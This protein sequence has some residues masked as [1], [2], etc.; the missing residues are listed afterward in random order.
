MIVCWFSS[1]LKCPIVRVSH[2]YLVVSV[3][4]SSVDIVF[5]PGGT[6]RC[7]CGS[8]KNCAL[9]HLSW[10]E[11]PPFRALEHNV[12]RIEKTAVAVLS[13]SPVTF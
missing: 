8:L 2:G 9:H 6:F 12:T 7:L 13:L 10:S 5:I 1:L 4:L 3:Q 11:S